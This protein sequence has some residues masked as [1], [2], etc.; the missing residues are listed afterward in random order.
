MKTNL[1]QT[2][3]ENQ[4][5]LIMGILNVTPDSF[6]D[7]GE[8]DAVD[9]AVERALLMVKQGA[10]IIDI[11][12]ESTRPN[13]Q[14]VSEAEELARVLPVI[15]GI[16]QQSDIAISV[17][18]SS[19]AVMQ[20]AIKAG[21]NLINDVRAL[22]RP[23][24]IESAAA[25]GLPVCLMHMQ[26]QPSNMQDAPQY[27]DVVSDVSQFLKSRVTACIAGGIKPEN[28]ILDPGFGFGKT[29]EQ[30]YT[31]LNKLKQLQQLGFPILAGLSRKNMIGQATGKP[32]EQRTAGSV[33]G[34]L[35]CAQQ[36]ARILRVHDVAETVDAIA[37][38]KASLGNC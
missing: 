26:G 37:V 2:I 35:L 18:T 3:H 1:I 7:G 4:L 11:G 6:S 14:A 30:N 12:G 32:V 5:P 16:R 19:A 8:F 31:L 38:Y 28:I 24:A 36:G 33:A 9:L 29:T 25:S 21:V 15:Q 10:D 17:D 22:S 27:T 20:Q 23:D 34:A 13:A